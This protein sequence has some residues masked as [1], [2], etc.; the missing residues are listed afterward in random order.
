[1][2]L[3]DDGTFTCNRT[4]DKHL[5]RK[6]NALGLNYHLLNSDKVSY[7]WIVIDYLTAEGLHRKLV[8]TRDY[9]LRY[10][11]LYHF[12][13]QG[14]ELQSFLQIDHFGIEKARLFEAKKVIQQN[15]F[16]DEYGIKQHSNALRRMPDYP[17]K[18]R[19]NFL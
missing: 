12:A 8:T 14:F 19:A 18:Y 11:K 3:S 6:L 2:N 16:G 17:D 1:M 15:L 10:G 4:E 9:F 5:F 7:K 13:K